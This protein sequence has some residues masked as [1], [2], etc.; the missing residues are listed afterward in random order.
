MTTNPS[1]T[2]SSSE[3]T[4]TPHSSAQPDQPTKAPFPPRAPNVDADNSD[5]VPAAIAAC[6]DQLKESIDQP[7]RVQGLKSMATG[8]FQAMLTRMTNKKDEEMNEMR[9]KGRDIEKLVR[10]IDER[11]EKDRGCGMAEGSRI[12]E[13]EDVKY[14]EELS[15][16]LFS[17]TVRCKCTVEL[18]HVVTSL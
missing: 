18:L 7:D 11:R 10:E 3:P 8:D 17:P 12:V 6:I 2:S 15:Y 5:E 4:T 14:S 1:S 16:V 9:K 13:S